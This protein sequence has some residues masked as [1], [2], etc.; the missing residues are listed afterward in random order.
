M[1][2]ESNEGSYIRVG[3]PRPDCF[4]IGVL[5]ILR[6]LGSA[7]MMICAV[8]LAALGDHPAYVQSRLKF[9]DSSV[10]SM[11]TAVWMAKESGAFEK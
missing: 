5:M 9:A 8:L 10:D 3:L 11:A 4:T 2:G 7:L 1:K 6:W